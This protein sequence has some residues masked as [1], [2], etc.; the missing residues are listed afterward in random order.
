MQSSTWAR[1][2][3]DA[4]VRKERKVQSVLT[5][6]A[7]Q[8][9]AGSRLLVSLSTTLRH[10][11]GAVQAPERCSSQSSARVAPVWSHPGILCAASL[12][13]SSTDAGSGEG[14]DGGGALGGANGAVGAIAALGGTRSA[15]SAVSMGLPR[16]LCSASCPTLQCSLHSCVLQHLDPDSEAEHRKC[17]LLDHDLFTSYGPGLGP[18][19]DPDPAVV[20]DGANQLDHLHLSA[21]PPCTGRGHCHGPSG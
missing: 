1:K 18:G 16:P 5:H 15:G 7:V 20:S 21:A 19:P 17:P 10:L 14:S 11:S 4:R 9:P 12:R 2:V 13:W 8:A 6:A 3:Q